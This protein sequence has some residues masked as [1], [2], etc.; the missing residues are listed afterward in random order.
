MTNSPINNEPN[1]RRRHRLR[2]VLI[3]GGIGLGVASLGTW[4]AA[5]WFIRNRLAPIVAGQLSNLLQRPVEVGQIQPFTFTDPTTIRVGPSTIPPTATNPNNAS[6]EGI[7]IR[8]S[9]LPLL[10]QQTVNVDV[11]LMGLN[12]YLE[13]GSDGGWI[14]TELKQSDGE[15]PIQL[16]YGAININAADANVDLQPYTKDNSGE[17]ISLDVNQLGLNLADNNQNI[18]ASID[19]LLEEGGEVEGEVKVALEPKDLQIKVK[20]DRVNLDQ[21]SGLLK[22]EG[23]I[24]EAGEVTANLDSRFN[25]GYQFST[26]RGT[27]NL[28]EVKADIEDLE[29]PLRSVDGQL[30]FS[31]RRATIQNLTGGL[32]D[33]AAE[34]NGTVDVSTEPEFNLSKTELNLDIDILPIPIS[35]LIETAGS[36]QA[37]PI[38]LPIPISGEVEANF[39]VTRT[40]A[41]PQVSAIIATTQPTQ[42]DRVLFDNIATEFTATTELTEEF[43]LKSDPIIAIESLEINPSFGGEITGEGNIELT[44]LKQLVS[45]DD[46]TQT[47]NEDADN[48][49]NPDIQ[50]D[51]NVNQIPGDSLLRT[52]GVSPQ[53]RI[54]NLSADVAVDGNVAEL[55]ADASFNLPSASYPISGVANLANNQLNSTVEIAEG[56]VDITAAKQQQNFTANIDANNLA[57]TPLVTLGLPFSGLSDSVKTQIANINL[58]DGRLNLEADVSGSLDNLNPNTLNVD[59]DVQVSLGDR[60]ITAN[61]QLNQ[62][63]INANYNTDALPLNRLIDAGLPFANLDP[64]TATKIQALDVRNGTLTSQ[65]TIIGNLSSLDNILAEAG[66]EVNLGNL[67]GIITAETQLEQGA[68]QANVNTNSIPL[69]PLIDA[70]LPWANLSPEVATQVQS[71]NLRN[72]SIQA[73]GNIIG[74]LDNITDASGDI[75][76]QVNLGNLGGMINAESEINQGNFIANV[77]ANSVALQPLINAGLPIANLSP[78]LDREIRALDLRNGSLQAIATANGNLANLTPSGIRATLDSTVN[79]GNQGGLV[80]ATGSAEAGQW[81]ARVEG[82]QIALNR[83]SQLVESQTRDAAPSILTQAENLPLLRGLLNT[84]LQANGSLSNFNPATIEGAANLRLTELPILRQPFEAIARWNGEQ[85]NIQKAE[86]EPFSTSGTIALNLQ[87]SGVPQLGNLN[88][89]VRVSEFD[90][91]SPLAQRLLSALPQEVM[92]D[93]GQTIAGAI[94][95]DGKVTGSLPNLNVDG[96]IRLENFALRELVFDPIL[97]GDIQAQ[98]GGGISLDLAGQQDNIELVL[99]EQYLPV[100]FLLQRGEIIARGQ[101]QGNDLIVD[102]EQFPLGAL[103]L[104]PLA[105]QGIGSLKG[106][107]SANLVISDLPTLDPN[108]ID[109]VGTINI[110]NPALGYI[111]LEQF[112]TDISYVNG[113]A[114]INQGILQ[115]ARIEEG[116]V[117][118]GETEILISATANVEEILGDLQSGVALFS[119][120]NTEANTDIPPQF[121][122]NIDIPNGQLQEVLTTLELYRLED[123]GRGIQP[124][125]YA[126]AKAVQ[127]LKVGFDNDETVTL[128]QQLRRLAE[129]QAL[130]QQQEEVAE[131]GLPL[132][133][134]K[135]VEGTF[136]ASLSAQGSL[137]SGIT[138]EANIDNQGNWQ[139][140]DLTADNFVLDAIFQDNVLRIEPILLTADETLYD[141]R[142]QLDLTTQKPSGQFEVKNLSLTAIERYYDVPGIDLA[143]DFNLTAF[144]S[145]SI[146]DPQ[147]T[148]EFNLAD[149]LIN[150]EEIEEARGSFTYNEAIFRLGGDFFVAETAENPI[151]YQAK[152]P[153]RLPF[154]EVNPS[155]NELLAELEIQDEGFKI[156]NVLNPEIDWVE[157]KGDLDLKIEGQLLQNN[158]GE[159][160]FINSRIIPM[161][162]LSLQDVVLEANSLEQSIVDLG[163]KAE[164]RNNLIQVGEV[165][166]V[167][168][169]ETIKGIQGQLQGEN[170][171]GT[172]ELAGILPLFPKDQVNPDEPTLNNSLQLALTSLDLNVDELYEGLAE[173]NIIVTRAAL[174]PNIGGFIAISQ[175]VVTLPSGGGG[176]G[177]GGNG[178]GG[179]GLSQI[180][181]DI[182]LNDFKIS[183]GENVRIQS[184]PVG[185]LFDAP[186]LDIGTEG[187]ITVNGDLDSIDSIRPEGEIV[188]TGGAIDLY[189]NRFT[190]DKGYPQR[191]IF[192]P[193]QGLEPTIDVRLVTKVTETNRAINPPSAIFPE[194]QNI[195]SPARFGTVRTIR[196]IATAKGPASQLNDIVELKSSPPR[197]DTQ[198]IALLGGSVIEGVTGDSTLLLANL[199]SAEIFNEVQRA[200]T[201]ATGLNEFR[202]Y[203]A[204]LEDNSSSGASA[205]GLGLEI[206]LDITDNVSASLTRVLAG[207]QPT[208]LGVNYRVN[209]ELLLR[210]ETD[211]QNSS[212]IRFEYE[213]RF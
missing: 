130:I 18:T 42:V 49:F 28:D 144:I 200:V 135:E 203:P 38:T 122:V 48:P 55:E 56:T 5:A 166:T 19:T 170:G 35:S 161:G 139:W 180:P 72:G 148:G 136:I 158:N 212:V 196:V 87:G 61:A 128:L 151:T 187:T 138:A 168:G 132:P 175:A 59:S 63:D 204:R 26:L 3:W 201:K 174:E 79:L 210:G 4:F 52:Y 110:E 78:D 90:F 182:G 68:F 23:V 75:Q 85:I 47:S 57:L 83:F 16:N 89:D 80:T 153:Y 145:G 39:N 152:I 118:P 164:F 185:Q 10:L 178:A 41:N 184:A 25:D 32:G 13:E 65:G 97:T 60:N 104:A 12:A 74:N 71:L 198:L 206:G 99:N 36:F 194:E 76:A 93:D 92:A 44:G 96:D 177:G 114:E 199:A 64:Q 50:F 82:D 176:D 188:L 34:V 2:R 11:D 183:L 162:S 84:E 211:F 9:V 195:P 190:F 94:S 27:L 105:S 131:E 207:G 169:K 62:G 67:G 108:Q 181:I 137:T 51:L 117:L 209:D 123:L 81:Q 157:G 58:N 15:S 20:A 141:F 6:V 126:P 121:T 125:I 30:Q 88:L 73:R 124:P 7:N 24:F 140:G 155:S 129:I 43:Q 172:F 22:D 127:P 31:G 213:V 142:G 119:E 8:L 149:G 102:I 193:E 109:V 120:T 160:D 107:T 112:Q 150:N 165:V 53:F 197:S 86:T 192:S 186:I 54:G 113:L 179:G 171:T 202:L 37:E 29:K 163:G 115:L 77:E 208:R 33:V 45:Q 134:L 143:G 1:P 70:G 95:F 103:G 40:L 159:I 21:F 98:L 133:P 147:V 205:L 14:R 189:T 91:Q 156:I 154:A 116:V 191:A 17:L 167:Q 69:N 66:A 46:S 173:G 146:K 111:N 106:K 100:S 101:T